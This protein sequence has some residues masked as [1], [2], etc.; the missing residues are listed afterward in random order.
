MYTYQLQHQL[1]NQQLAALRLH[2]LA[3][4]DQQ[5]EIP[6]QQLAVLDQQSVAQMEVVPAQIV[7]T[8]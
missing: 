6:H 2:W 3:V 7:S 8:I 4:L 5:L 1:L